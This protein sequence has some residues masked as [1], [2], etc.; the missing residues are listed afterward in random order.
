MSYGYIHNSA[1]QFI[2]PTLNSTKAAAEAASI[3]LPLGNQSWTSVS[4]L[5]APGAGSY[6]IASFSYLLVYK[7]LSI[8]SSMDKTRAKALVDFLWWA[9]HDGQSLA[10]NLQ[11]VPLPKSVVAIDE[12]SINSI[13]FKGEPVK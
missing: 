9:V 5:N 13:T 12:A 10:P 11:Y 6:P 2:E 7:E 1:S 8:L 4:I 3:S